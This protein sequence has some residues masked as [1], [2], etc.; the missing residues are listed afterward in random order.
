A[1]RVGGGEHAVVAGQLA[2]QAKTAL[3]PEEN[4][5]QREEDE[6]DLLGKVDPVVVAAQMLALMEND[7]LQFRGR[8]T[9]IEAGRYQDAGRQETDDAGLNDVVRGAEKYR[10]CSL[11]T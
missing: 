10:T 1:G 6:D 11:D 9:R 8:K 2:L 7:M 3:N 5:I 4:R